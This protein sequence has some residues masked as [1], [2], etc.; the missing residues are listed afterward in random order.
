MIHRLKIRYTPSDAFF[1]GRIYGV[2]PAVFVVIW[3]A[4][5]PKWGMA[6]VTPAEDQLDISYLE[7]EEYA[8][9]AC[10]ESTRLE[11][12]EE[13]VDKDEEYVCLPSCESTEQEEEEEM[14]DEQQMLFEGSDRVCVCFRHHL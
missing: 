5:V 1:S 9:M 11:E 12:D 8:Y 7:D 13:S 14:D 3:L 10:S 2:E 6:L 4:G